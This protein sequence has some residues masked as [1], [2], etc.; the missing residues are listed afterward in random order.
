MECN[1]TPSFMMKCEIYRIHAVPAASSPGLCGAKDRML[2]ELTMHA[3]AGH[4]G[5]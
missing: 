1:F 5:S 4:K 3:D 2:I